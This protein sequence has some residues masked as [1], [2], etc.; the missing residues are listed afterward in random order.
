M[1]VVEPSFLMQNIF[2][3]FVPYFAYFLGIF[4]RKTVLPGANSPIL[5]HQLLLGIPIGLVIVSPF[6]MFLRSAMSSDVPVYLFNIGIIIEHGMVV[7]ETAT[8]HLK[9]LTQRRSIA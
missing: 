1:T 8:I 2:V 9:K 4:I 5:T 6:L 7:Q 3:W